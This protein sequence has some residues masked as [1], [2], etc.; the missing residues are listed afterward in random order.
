L[1]WKGQRCGKPSQ[2]WL[3]NGCTIAAERGVLPQNEGLAPEP[4]SLIPN[5]SVWNREFAKPLQGPKLLPGGFKCALSGFDHSRC[6]ALTFLRIL[7]ATDFKIPGK[8]AG[9]GRESQTL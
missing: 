6:K 5:N 4:N 9:S 3:H 1:R 7:D 2:F 8:G